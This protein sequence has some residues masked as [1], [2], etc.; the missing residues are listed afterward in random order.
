ME[1]NLGM[2]AALREVA[3]GHR[4]TPA[5][6][7]LAWTM[8]R[9]PQVSPVPGAKRV[10]HVEENAAAAAVALAP[11]ALARLDAAFEPGAVAGDRYPEVQMRRLNL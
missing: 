6:A 10:A 7:A 2:L 3:A 9:H 1:K 4:C 8:A 11:A 5:Q